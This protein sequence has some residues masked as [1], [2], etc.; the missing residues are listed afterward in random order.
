MNHHRNWLAVTALMFWVAI[1]VHAQGEKLV[2]PAGTPED[3]ALQAISKETDADKRTAMYEDFVQKF[4]SNPV[5]V[6][7]GNWQLAQ[8][9]QEKGDFEKA[10]SAG[11]KAAAAAPHD[12]DI[13][14]SLVSIAQQAKADD[15]VFN[16]S[17]QGGDTFNALSSADDKAAAQSSHDFLEAA[18]YNVIVTAPNAKGRVAYIERFTPAFPDSRFADSITSYAMMSFSELNDMPR[19]VAYGEKVLAKNPENLPTLLL[20]AYAYSDDAKPGSLAKSVSYA[21]KAIAVAKADAPDADASRKASAGV[22]HSTLGYDLMK[23]DKTQAAVSEL[24]TATVLLKGQDQQADALALYRLGYA[25]AKLNKVSDAREVL[26]EAV[27]IS[28]PVQQPAR[29]LLTKVNA[30][31]AQGR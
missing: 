22:A 27:K 10:L 17:V 30:A 24:K 1:F 7:Y 20:L 16:Y 11:D 18:A 12:M 3:Q 29:D 13:L 15:K 21:Q 26:T 9:Y 14:V 25:Y 2:I 4:S 8:A 31:R 23:Q 28:G 5:A 19:L 6:A